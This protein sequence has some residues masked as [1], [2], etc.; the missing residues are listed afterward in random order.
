M[1]LKFDFGTSNLSYMHLL[2]VD[3]SLCSK[4][5]T[6][7]DLF[8]FTKD[9][10]L[11]SN[12]FGKIDSNL[13]LC[14]DTI[15]CVEYRFEEISIDLDLFL[16]TVDR[17]QNVSLVLLSYANYQVSSI[18]PRITGIFPISLCPM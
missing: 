4:R 11:F 14:L 18:C 1:V 17:F 5:K 13:S 16:D 12:R 10:L 2:I 8:T 9:F 7:L 6:H 3:L 15:N